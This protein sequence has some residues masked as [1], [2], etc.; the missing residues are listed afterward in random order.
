M[1]FIGKLEPGD[2]VDKIIRDITLLNHLTVTIQNGRYFIGK[3]K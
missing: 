1:Y 2:S 3:G